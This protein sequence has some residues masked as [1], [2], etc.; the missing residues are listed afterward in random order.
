M[1]EREHPAARATGHD[2]LKA[3]YGGLAEIGREVGDDEEVILLRHNP[4][5][6]VILGNVRELV[7]QIHLNY[8]FDVS[9]ENS[10]T[11]VDLIPLG[12]DAVIDQAVFIIGKIHQAAEVLPEANGIDN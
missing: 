9:A 2:T 8:F 10:Q 4:G 7:P 12:P 5:L 1:H 6:T 11:V 3:L